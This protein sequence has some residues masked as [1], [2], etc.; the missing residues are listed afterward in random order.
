MTACTLPTKKILPDV[1][2]M[3]SAE[4]TRSLSGELTWAREVEESRNRRDSQR[5]FIS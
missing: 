4:R 5:Y 2:F 1:R 3:E